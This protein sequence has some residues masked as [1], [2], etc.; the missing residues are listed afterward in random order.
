ML[1]GVPAETAAAE[2]RVAVTTETAK[3]LKAQGHQVRVTSRRPGG[4]RTDDHQLRG[5]A[6]KVLHVANGQLVEK[7]VPM[8]NAFNEVLR[9]DY[10]KDSIGG[11]SRW[12]KVIEKAGIPFRLT[13]PHKAFRP[14]V[15]EEQAVVAEK[16][17]L[18]PCPSPS[19]SR[20]DSAP[21]RVGTGGRERSERY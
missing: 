11:V 17:R 20:S 1:I 3:K 8:L 9:D 19:P 15:L 16:E 7:E 13:T 5:Q 14:R 18:R 10:S 6:Y 12:N 21:T 2:T 4:K